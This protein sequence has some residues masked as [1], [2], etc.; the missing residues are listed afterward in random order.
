MD[1]VPLIERA[2]L[3][4]AVGLQRQ[5]YQLLRW[6]ETALT[7]GFI[8][9]EAVERYAD[10]GASALAW[11]DEHYL[12]LPLRARPEREDLPAFARF[13]T[14]YL[15]ST[16]DLDDDPGDGGF[17]G[18]MLY[19]RMNFEKEPTR[20]HFRPRKLGR[21]EREGADDMRRESVRALAKLNDR[22]ETAVAR[23]VARPEMRPATSRL[24]YAKDLLRRVDGV[25]Q[26]GA[27]LDLWRAFAWTPE[28]SPVKG[29]QLRTD[30]LLAA[31]QVLAHALLTSPP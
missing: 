7:D 9:P 13:F 8:T 28:G 27:T 4:R 29:F 18:W 2:P 31:Q 22:D 10:Q 23:L 15:R 14:T 21:A 19:N 25:A 6:L 30:D 26:G 5:S 3:H 16:F 17:Y 24:A 11:L 12:N 20:Q 1:F